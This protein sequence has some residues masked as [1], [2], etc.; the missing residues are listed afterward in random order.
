MKWNQMKSNQITFCRDGQRFLNECFSKS[1][2][3]FGF[4]ARSLPMFWCFFY[5]KNLNQFLNISRIFLGI[6]V[7]LFN[8]IVTLD[9]I[10]SH[11]IASQRIT[12]HHIAS[13]HIA[14]HHI[15]SHHNA[16]HRI[17]SLTLKLALALALAWSTSTSMKH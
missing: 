13:H 11:H 9:Q 3:H 6:T 4:S 15:A 7:I 8:K 12:S 16:S 1:C 10:T 14:S 2:P 17:A 5:I